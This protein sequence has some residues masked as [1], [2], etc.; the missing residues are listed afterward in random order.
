MKI[1]LNIWRQHNSSS[2]GHFEKFEMDNI[3][4]EISLLELL[5]TLNI[6]LVREGKEPIVF[7][8]DCREGICGQCGFVI[9]G[10]A[11]GPSNNTSTCQIHMR[12]FKDGDTLYLEPFRSIAFPIRKDLS[13]DRSAFDRIIMAGGYISVNTG[14]APEANSIPIGKNQYEMAM[15]AA[16]CIGCGACV[17]ACPNGSAALFTGGKIAHLYHLPQGKIEH[18][19]RAITMVNQMDK[20][21]FGACSNHAT[22]EAVCPAGLTIAQIAL[23]NR[24][25]IKVNTT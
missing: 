16:A 1:T 21:G 24:S 10:D 23:M 15:D 17:A 8:H 11:H 14:Q 7:D 4:P 18:E 5:D 9:N 22:C 3:Q 13:V 19:V 25:Y 20:E 6:R 2:K 12:S